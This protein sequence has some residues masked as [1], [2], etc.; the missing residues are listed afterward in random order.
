MRKKQ[1]ESPVI[2]NDSELRNLFTRH[3]N[4]YDRHED[5]VFS[6]PTYFSPMREKYMLNKSL[7][8]LGS[9]D[10]REGSF[11][12]RETSNETHSISSVHFGNES[13]AKLKWYFG[14]TKALKVE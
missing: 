14:I 10:L 1:K 9:E 11:C 2:S 6:S 7:Q 4:Y 12:M 3:V 13:L 8:E 5:T